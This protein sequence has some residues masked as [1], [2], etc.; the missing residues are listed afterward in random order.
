[1]TRGD[2]ALGVLIPVLSCAVVII[3]G[4]LALARGKGNASL[5]EGCLEVAQL[6]SLHAACQQSGFNVKQRVRVLGLD[7]PSSEAD[8]AAGLLQSKPC[9]C[10]AGGWGVRQAVSHLMPSHMGIHGCPT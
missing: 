10:L 8:S 6:W 1:M 9:L 5:A 4:R 7:L 2:S 3:L